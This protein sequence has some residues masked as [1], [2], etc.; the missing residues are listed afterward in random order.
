MGN[1]LWI[2]EYLFY[3]TGEMRAKIPHTPHETPVVFLFI[4][5]LQN[6][7]IKLDLASQCND[8]YVNKIYL[9]ISVNLSQSCYKDEKLTLK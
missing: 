9:G 2:D 8:S 7:I 5:K 1:I 6:K 4:V 3:V